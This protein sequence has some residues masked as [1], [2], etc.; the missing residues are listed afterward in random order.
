MKLT[1]LASSIIIGSA[2]PMMALA[3]SPTQQNQTITPPTKAQLQNMAYANGHDLGL[4]LKARNLQKYVPEVIQGLKDSI[5]GKAISQ[6]KVAEAQQTSIAL[7]R[8]QANNFYQQQI[9]LHNKY[10]QRIEIA[11]GWEKQ[12]DLYVKITKGLNSSKETSPTDKDTIALSQTVSLLVPSKDGQIT[13]K[14]DGPAR[15]AT[16]PLS[17]LDTTT[18]KLLKQMK[19]GDTVEALVPPTDMTIESGKPTAPPLPAR[20]YTIKLLKI[21]NTQNKAALPAN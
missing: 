13:P 19:P 9:D 20:I 5:D 10:V 15:E 1:L 7:A 11:K 17:Q 18:Q 8:I 14:A 4:Q 6:S 3:N 2:L 12:G 16:V 21:V